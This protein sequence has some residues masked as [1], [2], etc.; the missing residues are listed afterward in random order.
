M[1]EFVE[2]SLW[3]SPKHPLNIHDEFRGVISIEACAWHYV[4]KYINDDEPTIDVFIA[5][6]LCD[7]MCMQDS[8]SHSVN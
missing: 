2:Q 4:R 5:I 8:K 1:L 7:N 3:S 6:S